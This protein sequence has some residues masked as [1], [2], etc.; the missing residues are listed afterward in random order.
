M[1]RKYNCDSGKGDRGGGG[2][3][4]CLYRSFHPDILLE[5]GSSSGGGGGG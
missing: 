5:F 2:A 4:Y 1:E 3:C